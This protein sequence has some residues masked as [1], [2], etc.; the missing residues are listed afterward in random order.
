MSQTFL[1]LGG[2][3]NTG[4]LMAEFLLKETDVKLVL[5]GRNLEKAEALA[6]ALNHKFQVNRVSSMRV[7]AAAPASLKNAFEK[8][9]F[10]IVASSTSAYVKNIATAAIAAGI[11]Y[12][13]FQFSTANFNTLNSLKQDIARAGCCF[14]AEAGFHPGLPA[15]LVRF[16]VPYFD[17]LELANVASVIKLNWKQ[18]DLSDSTVDEMVEEFNNFQTSFF[19]TDT[20]VEAGW[21][22][23]KKFYFGA[24]FGERPCFP[25]F[26][27]EMRSLPETVPSLKETGFF[28]GGLNWF[29]DYIVIPLSLAALAIG[30]EKAGKPV[31]QLLNWG[32][33][34]FSKPPYRTILLL[35]A[36]GW[37][38]GKYQT[39]RVKLSHEDGYVLT[40]IPAVACLLQYLD[41]SIRKPG[42]WLQANL[43]E[44]NR[45]LKDIERLGVAVEIAVA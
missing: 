1:V 31:G 42:L 18:I 21:S 43:V 10:A 8:V 32:L 33:K 2:T 23:T 37:K 11:D 17:S 20:W 40:A 41:G 5:A 9:D 36:S 39:V 16:A 28:V 44:P 13:D 25:M 22:E 15:V 34:T 3:G 29:V 7:D 24:E 30:P 27:E 35:E 6:T 45:L 4:R 19:Q 14:I 26:L 12:L 38:D